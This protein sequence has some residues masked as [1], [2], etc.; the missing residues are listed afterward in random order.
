MVGGTYIDKIVFVTSKSYHGIP[1]ISKNFALFYRKI[2]RYLYNFKYELDEQ[3]S[4][5]EL[6]KIKLDFNKQ[7]KQKKQKKAGAKI[8]KK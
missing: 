7:K 1:K 4:I 5:Q 6:K 2:S 8:L 3:E